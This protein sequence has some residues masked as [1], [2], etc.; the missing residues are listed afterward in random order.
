LIA[1]AVLPFL[2]VIAPPLPA[3]AGLAVGVDEE[4]PNLVTPGRV[5]PE[6]APSRDR[7]AALKPAFVRLDVIWSRVQPSAN[8]PPQ[9]DAENAGCVRD[10]P[11]CAPFRGVRDQL[12]AL[13]ARRA[14]DG[15]GWEPYVVLFGAP[16]WATQERTGCVPEGVGPTGLAI[17]DDALPA[18]R[19]F[20]A[21]LLEL[22]RQEGIPLRLWSAWNEPNQPAFLAPQRERCSVRSPSLA[23]GSYARLVRELRAAL[24]AAAGDQRIVLGETAGYDRPLP[25]ATGAAEFIRGLPRDVACASDVWAQHAYVGG[26]EPGPAADLAADADR[27]GS[28]DLLREVR[29]ALDAAGCPREK[30]IWITETGVGGDKPGQARPT[31]EAALRDQCRAMDA[32]LRAWHAD[33]RVDAAFQYTFRE[34]DQYPV[35]LIDVGLS[36]AYPTAELWRVWSHRAPDAPPP[37][38]AC[39]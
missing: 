27:S 36:R 6:F 25:T 17:R 37:A 21:G 5:P 23:P 31:D 11:P 13:A 10:T 26:S 4:N 24:D 14:A 9:W 39:P 34:D 29:E 28:V 8:A 38:S 22:G 7:L 18:Y 15:G 19:R 1:A 12:R 16:E 2:G 3:P 20:V 30:H 35:G 32:A 33:P